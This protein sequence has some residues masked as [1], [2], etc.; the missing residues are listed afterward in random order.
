MICPE[1]EAYEIWGD[2]MQINRLFEMVYLLLNKKSV[3]AKELAERFEVSARTIY[4]DLDI[5]SSAGI[6]VYTSQGK[7]GGI[8]LMDHFVLNKSVLS[9]RDKNEILYALQSLAVAKSPESEK[10]LAK[11]NGFFDHKSSNWIEADLTP[12]GS[13]KDSQ[14]SFSKLKEAILNRRVICFEYFN[15]AGESSRRTVEPI[16]LIF[17]VYAWYL[18]GFCRSRK[19]YRTF[20]I[21][22]MSE[23]ILTD[24]HFEE[25]DIPENLSMEEDETSLISLQMNVTSD[26]AYRVFDDFSDTDIQRMDDG[27]FS[28]TV[29]L[30]ESNWLIGY[31]LSYGDSLTVLEPEHIRDKLRAQAVRISARYQT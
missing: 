15:A 11:L 7:G 17:K 5:L 26:S 6:P 3:T 29:R 20:K 4:R 8:S 28:I 1:A 19:A 31:L 9:E 22:R 12:W 14:N 25:R 23:I 16:K 21:S 13:G 10:V 27:S 18:H 2:E 30:P 24:E